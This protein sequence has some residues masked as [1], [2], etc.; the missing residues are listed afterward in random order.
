VFDYLQKF[1]NL[2]KEVRDKVSGQAAMDAIRELEKRY[3][4]DL[5]AVVIKIMVKEIKVDDLVSYFVSQFN[6]DRVRAEKLAKELKEK[7]L[8]NAV[9]YLGIGKMLSSASVR[10]E[11]YA[12]TLAHMKKSV[13]TSG[14]SATPAQK[15]RPTP[16]V[17]GASFFFSPEDEEEI[18]ELAKKIDG[19]V[20]GELFSDRI[21]ERLDKII[22]QAQINFGSQALA[23]RFKQ[24]LKTY[25]RGI[26]DRIETKQA[27]IKS[28]ESGGLNFDQESAERILLIT[29]SNLKNLGPFIE[30]TDKATAIRQ[31]AKT[32]IPA[33]PALQQVRQELKEE[34]FISLRDNG[35]RD[36]DYD[37]TSR[38]KEKKREDVGAKSSKLDTE[39]ELAPPPPKIRQASSPPPASHSMTDGPR[40]TLPGQRGQIGPSSG[41][42]TKSVPKAKTKPL[43][44]VHSTTKIEQIN[45]RRPVEIEGKVKMEDVKY[46]PKV[47][48]PIDELK[49]MNLINFRR[50]DQ[51]PNKIVAKIK[52]KIDLL[53]EEG[54]A[55]RLEGIRAWRTSPVNRLYLAMGQASISRNK[56][57][58]VIIE[59]RK[60]AGKEYLNSQE[61]EAIMDLNKDLRF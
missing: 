32:K 8:F 58:D 54:Y 25:L 14:E 7:V 37:F 30:Q 57:I 34:K 46:V 61:F 39:H 20:E 26:R 35:V 38:L 11:E 24:V 41:V 10:G 48:G 43:S 15:A 17:Q 29:D 22:K 16:S 1:N 2:P 50:L 40:P 21:E 9:E 42:K 23:E 28:F 56:P 6:L 36:I 60:M 27:L 47:M 13:S 12:G 4:V 5:A 53:E 44:T 59:E 55:K 45:I 31:P 19:Y 51:D 49:Y 18:R 3:G 33:R 52:Q